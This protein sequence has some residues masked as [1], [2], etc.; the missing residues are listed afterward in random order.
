MSKNFP[1]LI[2][3]HEKAGKE[4]KE[5]LAKELTAKM[6]HAIQQDYTLD[7]L[8][9]EYAEDEGDVFK[10]VDFRKLFGNDHSFHV[11][12]DVNY[13]CIIGVVWDEEAGI[14]MLAHKPEDGDI[15][16][17]HPCHE[18]LTPSDVYEAL[19]LLNEW[20]NKGL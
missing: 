10:G 7:D 17:A 11:N 18:Q 16:L 12:D 2:E 15:T 1:Q 4:L 19:R 3:E 20:M 6:R 8:D 9:D 14:A 5:Q 13:D